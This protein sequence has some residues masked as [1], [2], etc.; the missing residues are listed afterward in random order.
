[1]V[2]RFDLE[3]DRVALADVDHARVGADAG[4]QRGGRLALAANCLRCTLEDP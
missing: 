1:M 2:V 3:R 4:Q